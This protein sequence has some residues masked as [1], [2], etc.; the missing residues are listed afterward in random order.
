[1]NEA[2][3]PILDATDRSMLPV[4]IMNTIGNIINPISMKSEDVRVRLRASRKWEERRISINTSKMINPINIHSQHWNLAS[5]ER[6]GGYS[7]MREGDFDSL[8]ACAFI[9]LFS[10]RDL[11]STYRKSLQSGSTN[12]ALPAARMARCGSRLVSSG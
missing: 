7:P 1:M 12:L 3:I 10:P 2:L 11:R 4:M 5:K 8:P 9:S 6:R